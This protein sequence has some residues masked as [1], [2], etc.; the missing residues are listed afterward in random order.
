MPLMSAC[1]ALTTD[2]EIHLGDRDVGVMEKA[3][4]SC[5]QPVLCELVFFNHSSSHSHSP[6]TMMQELMSSSS[7]LRQIHGT[8]CCR[9]SQTLSY[10]KS[11]QPVSP[12]SPKS[13]ILLDEQKQV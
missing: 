11:L 3:S 7:T 1:F 13:C 10:L 6:K 4:A 9:R 2:A 12:A 8:S 5:T